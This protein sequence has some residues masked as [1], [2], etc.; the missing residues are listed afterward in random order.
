MEYE[1]EFKLKLEFKFKLFKFFKC[2]LELISELSK[3]R[4]L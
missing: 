2:M 3:N 4:K 1:L